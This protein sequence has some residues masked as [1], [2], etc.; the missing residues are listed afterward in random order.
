MS[1]HQTASTRVTV[2]GGGLA[3]CEAAWQLA[4]CGLAVELIE[5]RPLQ[6]SPAHATAELAELVCSNSL[7]S[8]AVGTAKG[9]LIAELDA[10]DS[11]IVRA[12]RAAAV[13]A[14]SALAVNRRA[15]SARVTEE[16]AALPQVE[17]VRAEATELPTA[18]AIVASGPLTSDTLAREIAR[19]AGA[20]H[21]YFFD[22]TSPIIEGESIDR[23]IV[24]AADRREQ[25][26]GDH[27]NCPLNKEEYD[28]FYDAL[29][30]AA[31]VTPH[32]FEA[33]L[34]FEGC[35]P[36][37]QLAARGRDTLRFGPMR[38]V[39]LIDPRT[40]QRPYA[41]AQLRREDAAGDLWNIIGFQTRMTWGAQRDVLR[42]LPGL[43]NAR[44]QRLGVIH[45]NTYVDGPRVLDAT[46][47]FRSRPGVRLAGQI[48][49]V[50]GYL[51]STAMGL[52]AARFT[53]AEL[54]GRTLPPL[55]P[56][57]LI[58][59]LLAYITSAE[60]QPIQPMNVTF[61]LL[62]PIAEIRGRAERKR[63]MHERSLADWRDWLARE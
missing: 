58:G 14:G 41:V 45:R 62:P 33:G 35:M 18:P 5:A 27:L 42:L 6:P 50:E 8:M 1:A 31:V 25:G 19:A 2:V 38:P 20:D 37:E 57:T 24:F 60:T 53:A 7:G 22:A 51:E 39:G 21:L 34:V 29:V 43:Q 54:A 30:Q 52:L 17:V 55:P 56:T 28:R 26:P 48:T 23:T 15:F 32:G 49:G 61:G 3:G 59:A 63:L 16:L 44:F 13:S 9:L 47:A 10:A 36:I 11:L 40:G 46:L 4:R 12:A